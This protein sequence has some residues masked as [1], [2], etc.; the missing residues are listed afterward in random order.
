MPGKEFWILRGISVAKNKL[1]NRWK[2]IK[3]YEAVTGKIN[4]IRGKTCQ[5]SI[6]VGSA[7]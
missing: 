3:F 1:Q 2:K 6:E 7:V 5:N 4:K